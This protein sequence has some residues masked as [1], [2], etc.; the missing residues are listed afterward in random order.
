MCI[1]CAAKCKNIGEVVPGLWLVQAIEHVAHIKAG[2]FGLVRSNGPDVV[3]SVE[4][5]PDPW[6]GFSDDDMNARRGK[7]YTD[8]DSN[9]ASFS[10]ACMTQL[11]LTTAYLIGRL[12]QASG[13]DHETDGSLE[14]WLFHRMGVLLGHSKAAETTMKVPVGDPRKGTPP[15]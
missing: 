15:S 12:C 7:E 3:W 6:D 11:D 4:P 13:Y 1:A 8:W 10:E 5:S 14:H 2:D 9:V